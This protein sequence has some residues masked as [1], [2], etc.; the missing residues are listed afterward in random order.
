MKVFKLIQVSIINNVK[1]VIFMYIY[2]VEVQ[3]SLIKHVSNALTKII[4]HKDNNVL[5]VI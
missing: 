4:W 2:I 1:S 3:H 5:N